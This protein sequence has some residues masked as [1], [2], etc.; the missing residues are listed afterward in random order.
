MKSPLINRGRQRLAWLLTIFLVVL[1]YA[2]QGQAAPL[3]RPISAQQPA[4]FI[5]IDS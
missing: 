2:A 3:R 4:W 5:H 1:Q